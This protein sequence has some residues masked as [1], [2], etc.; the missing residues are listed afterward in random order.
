[1]LTDGVFYAAN[2]L[3]GA[4]LQGAHTTS[5]STSPDMRVFEVNDEDGKPS[6]G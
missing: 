1:M 5:R 2:Q 6:S 4:D 3:Y